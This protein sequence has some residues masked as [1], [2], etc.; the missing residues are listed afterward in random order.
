M[1]SWHEWSLILFSWV[2]CPSVVLSCGSTKTFKGSPLLIMRI[3]LIFFA[4]IF[5]QLRH[6]SGTFYHLILDLVFVPTNSNHFSKHILCHRFSRTN[7]VASVFF[8]LFW[9]TAPWTLSR[10][11]ALQ[12]FIVIII[13]ITSQ[14]T[15]HVNSEPGNEALCA[16]P[17]IWSESSVCRR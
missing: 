5:L 2:F 8:R 4:F 12:V 17:L 13:I 15:E 7:L 16:V 1:L 14:N 6:A 11:C 10:V 9:F 3:H